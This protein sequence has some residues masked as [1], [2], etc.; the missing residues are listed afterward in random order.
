MF[1]LGLTNGPHSDAFPPAM[2]A[3]PHLGIPT[4]SGVIVAI[5][6]GVRAAPLAKS[7]DPLR[8]RRPL[9]GEKR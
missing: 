9:A 1:K 6:W 2:L 4:V 8:W 5:V 7:L 3:A